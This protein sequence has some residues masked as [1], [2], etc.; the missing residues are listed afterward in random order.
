MIEYNKLPP[1]QPPNDE[2]FEEN[3]V[4]VQNNEAKL[5]LTQLWEVIIKKKRLPGEKVIFCNVFNF[6]L[7]ITYV[8][9]LKIDTLF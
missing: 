4:V 1:T 9:N 5:S 7:L 6:V 8:F 3:R 2:F